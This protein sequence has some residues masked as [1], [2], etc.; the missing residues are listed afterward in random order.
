MSK[1]RG[2][3]S[4]FKSLSRKQEEK[5]KSSST[6]DEQVKLFTGD[7][8]PGHHRLSHIMQLRETATIGQYMLDRAIRG[9]PSILKAG[10]DRTYV[11]DA[12]EAID[13]EVEIQ[14]DKKTGEIIKKTFYNLYAL[15]DEL[16]AEFDL[17]WKTQTEHH[18]E[19]NQF[20]GGQL[21]QRFMDVLFYQRPLKSVAPMVGG[22]L[23]ERNLP[24]AP[25]VHP[26][27][28]TFRIEK[29]L[30]DLRW[31]YGR[32]AKHLSDAELNAIRQ[33]LHD[34][35][36][37]DIDGELS[38]A[39]IYKFLA[40]FREAGSPENL[41]L[42]SGGRDGL[43]GNVTH[44]RWHGLGLY[45]AWQDLLRAQ[46]GDKHHVNRQN[47][48]I[49]FLSDLGS[50]ESLYPDNWFEHFYLPDL[51]TKSGQPAR[52]KAQAAMFKD[53]RFIEFIDMFRKHEKCD[54]LSSLRFDSGR[55]SYSVKALKKINVWLKESVQ[56]SEGHIDEH[57]AIK[58]L[59]KQ[60]QANALVILDVL[61]N[62]V[63][64]GNGIVD[65]ALM[66][67]KKVVNAFIIK[68][69]KPTRIV[70]EMAREMS[71][72]IS[73]RNDIQKSQ[74]QNKT[75]NKK[76]AQ[77]MVEYKVPYS[78]TNVLKYRLA[79]DQGYDC[80]YC[81]KNMGVMEI[82]DGSAT[83]IEHIIPQSLTQVGRKYSEIVLAHRHC[84]DKKGKRVPME[85]FAFNTGPI[86]KL[87]MRLR[88]LKQDRK[89]MLLELPET[90]SNAI[91][92]AILDEFCDR[93]FNETAW[94]TKITATWLRSLGVNVE[95]TKGQ[96]TAQLRGQWQLESVIPEVRIIE[97]LPVYSSHD[98]KG[99]IKEAIVPAKAMFYDE[100]GKE[101]TLLWRY[102]N[103]QRLTPDEFAEL[104][105]TGLYLLEKR[106]DHRHHLIDA[107][108]T[109]LCNR[110]MVKRMADE[111]K[112][113]CEEEAKKPLE[114]QKKIRFGRRE[115]PMARLRDQVVSAVKYN[116]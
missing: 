29:T 87:V 69:G 33:A 51:P 82:Y 45:D 50:V 105:Q 1:G 99:E 109:A 104:R 14:V 110:S 95:C 46:E 12:C 52:Q 113:R 32:H 27:F 102:W 4:G 47:W 25:R 86:E 115:E 7:V 108:V 111:Y 88:E 81:G 63:K 30:A 42:G 43:L 77:N 114:I 39:K 44:K 34:P 13:D 8:Q 40:P 17:I 60:E 73:G 75:I 15:R 107:I 61:D 48:V 80:P 6:F 70:V 26:A 3:S 89:A 72:G 116:S 106:C 22:C 56:F 98:E 64:T 62:P 55:A 101:S 37:L 38:F 74:N 84:N 31:G 85:A 54:R 93:Q 24:R 58:D 20:A 66:Q 79:Q 92:D 18:P 68:H 23:L 83:N 71:Q 21:K 103:K 100:A 90:P 96:M 112:K 78:K 36:Q 76:A 49:S 97:G 5:L 19:L 9:L 53:P 35:I 65:V 91:D 28:Q 94:I 2:Y 57:S 10:T 16:K 11:T 41:N 67:V 59:Y